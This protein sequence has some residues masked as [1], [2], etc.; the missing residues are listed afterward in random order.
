MLKL[1][2]GSDLTDCTGFKETDELFGD[3]D[4][5]RPFAW[6]SCAYAQ[7]LKWQ[8]QLRDLALAE[9]EVQWVHGRIQETRAK[10][11]SWEVMKQETLMTDIKDGGS[12]LAT[13]V[14]RTRE[15]ALKCHAPSDLKSAEDVALR[16]KTFDDYSKRYADVLRFLGEVK[17]SIPAEAHKPELYTQED[18]EALERLRDQAISVFQEAAPP[19]PAQGE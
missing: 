9:P 14:D 11:P 17:E 12:W 2:K 3:D 10:L 15:E 7:L 5:P 19:A 18:R 13:Q 6:L 1:P 4:E 8:F 16:L